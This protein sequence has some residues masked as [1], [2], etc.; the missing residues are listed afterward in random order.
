[1]NSKALKALEQ[2]V[3]WST[4][5]SVSINQMER[6]SCERTVWRF[7]ETS[8]WTPRGPSMMQYQRL[9]DDWRNTGNPPQIQNPPNQIVDNPLKKQNCKLLLLF[10]CRKA[11]VLCSQCQ[12]DSV[13]W[14]Q[15]FT[16]SALCDGCN[17]APEHIQFTWSLYLVNAS[18]KPLLEGKTI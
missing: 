3:Q 5:S 14:D 12:G 4:W 16:I 13:H 18:S 1:M 7:I 2:D 8:R 11:Y 9:S 6:V 17:V 15:S 10:L